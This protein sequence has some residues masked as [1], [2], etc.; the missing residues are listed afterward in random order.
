MNDVSALTRRVESPERR[1][2]WT[3]TLAAILAT[4]VIMGA[5]M[6]TR[7]P[8]DVLRARGIVLTDAADKPRLVL[9]PMADVSDDARL[10]GTVGLVVLDAAGRLNV[11]LGSKTPLVHRDGSIGKR[12]E[13]DAGFVVYDPRSGGERGGFGPQSL[14]REAA[15]MDP[16][17]VRQRLP[18]AAGSAPFVS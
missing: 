8:D 9:A 12:V 3:V 13:A 15:T 5:C 18:G 2:R 6:A 14:S 10:A 11:A 1:W 16:R 7:N 4:L 17:D